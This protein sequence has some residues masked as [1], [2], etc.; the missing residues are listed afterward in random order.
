VNRRG[1]FGFNFS[2]STVNCQLFTVSRSDLKRDKRPR[3]AGLRTV[4]KQ[5]HAKRFSPLHGHK[6]H[7]P[8]NVVTIYKVPYLRLVK[9]CISFQSPDPVFNGA[10]KSG[11]DLKAIVGNAAGDHGRLLTF[12]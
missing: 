2:L 9:G 10:A 7:L 1:G 5:P 11:A 8:P 4:Q 3:H 12:L 6:P